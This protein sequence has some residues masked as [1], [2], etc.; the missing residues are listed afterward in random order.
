MEPDNFVCRY[1]QVYYVETDERMIVNPVAIKPAVFTSRIEWMDTSRGQ[2]VQLGN[3]SSETGKSDEA[4]ILIEITSESG[5]HY[6]LRKLTLDLYNQ[7]V[8]ERVMLP[9]DFHSDEAV[10]KFYLE[11][12]FE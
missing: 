4:P 5:E 10:Q 11:A 12:D 3:I 8:K 6:R 9:P 7:Y 1:N 2:V